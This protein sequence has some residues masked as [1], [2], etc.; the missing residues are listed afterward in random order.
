MP[1]NDSRRAEDHI[2]GLQ[3]FQFA[4][5]DLMKPHAVSGN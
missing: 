4:A 1:V 5:F 3:N 2:T